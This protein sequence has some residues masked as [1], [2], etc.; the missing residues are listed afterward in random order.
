MTSLIQNLGWT[1]LKTRHKNSR[2]VSMFKILNELVEIPINDCLIPADRRTRGGH[3][4]GYNHLRPNTTLGQ[5]S[6][7]HRTIPDWCCWITFQ[8]LKFKLKE[9]KR[10]IL[11]ILSPF[12]HCFHNFVVS[13]FHFAVSHCFFVDSYTRCLVSFFCCLSSLPSLVF[14]LAIPLFH[15][16]LV[17]YFRCFALSYIRN[18]LFPLLIHSPPITSPSEMFEWSVCPVMWILI[19][20]LIYYMAIRLLPRFLC[21]TYKTTKVRNN[22]CTKQQKDVTTKVQCAAV[23]YFDPQL[24]LNLFIFNIFFNLH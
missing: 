16:F 8:S 19:V 9:E 7:W 23:Y 24:H 18:H 3:N 11:W 12:R 20:S 21:Q 10:C 6:F 4:Q 13:H 1:D 17:S 15:T 22:E 2:L 5:N 14:C